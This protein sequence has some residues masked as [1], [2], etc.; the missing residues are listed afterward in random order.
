M[1]ALRLDAVHAL[2]DDGPKHLLRELAEEVEA[3]SADV[4]RPLSLIAESDLNDPTLITAREAGGYG[5]TAQWSDDYHHAIHVNL[6]GETTGYYSD[7]DSVAALAKVLT[8]AYFHDGTY[9]S[10][11]GAEHGVPV[12]V[13]AVPSWRFVVFAQDHDQVGNRA[14][15][16][17]LTATLDER[18]LS[19]AAVLNLLSPFTPMLF[20]GEEWGASTPWQ[21][22]TSHPEPELGEATAIGRIEEF[23]RMGW[24]PSVVPDPQ[25][26]GTFIRSNLDWAELDRAPHDRILALHR[27]LLSLRRQYPGFTDP[28]FSTTACVYDE[29]ERWIR[30][31]RPGLAIL[32]NFSDRPCDLPPPS[33][34]ALLVIG[35]LEQDEA[36][37]HLGPRSAAVLELPQL[38]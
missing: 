36:G 23:E 12:D 38:G 1:D 16:D 28:R 10:F 27:T 17:R 32:V 3:L 20:M 29:D 35:E 33:G 14:T 21:F 13:D 25:D 30:I 37:L 8:S 19:I 31:D 11:R 18:G 2:V 22:F 6:T 4:R 34:S 5:L 26:P 9:S 24:D 7:F 15:G